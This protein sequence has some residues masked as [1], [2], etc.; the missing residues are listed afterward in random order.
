[1]SMNKKIGKGIL[2]SL[3]L[4][5][6]VFAAGTQL[7][8]RPNII[9][10]LADDMGVGDF[11][12]GG[13][14]PSRTPVLDKL[15]SK[16]TVLKQHYA[17]SAVCSPSRACLL[18]GRYPQRTGVLDTQKV[19]NLRNL[20]LDERTIADVL[21]DAGYVT[22]LI[23]K[24]HLGKSE[25][26]YYPW[27]RGFSHVAVLDKT[28]HWD[29][30]LN[31]N[32]VQEESDGRY[33]ADV[34]NDDAVQFIRTHKDEPFFLYLAHFAPHEPLLAVEED[35]AQ[36]RV[37]GFNEKVSTLYAMIYRMDQGIGRVLRELKAQGLDENTLVIFASDNGAHFATSWLDRTS[38]TRFNCGL[39][40]HKDLVYEG[41]IRVPAF[42]FWPAGKLKS[43]SIDSPTH[44]ADWF[45]TLLAVAGVPVPED[46]PPLDG[47]NL[48]PLLRGEIQ[49]QSTSFCWQYSR[50][51]PTDRYNIAIREG[52]WKLIRPVEGDG[53][54]GPVLGILPPKGIAKTDA[55]LDSAKRYI[56]EILDRPVAQLFNLKDD[57]FEQNDLA[58]QNPEKVMEMEKQLNCWFSSIMT[59]CTTRLSHFDF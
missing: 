3:L 28:H 30:I 7:S 2:L 47:R 40:G 54:D 45:P 41:G 5:G 52:D 44:F 31:R 55:Q 46:N 51:Y 43:G 19:Y 15:A 27:N 34:L 38:V 20:S 8:E 17:G 33:L 21:S 37:A 48:L 39:R 10:I 4:A 59:D 29:W 49:G 13:G 26:E 23:G 12:S 24:W 11:G 9:F 50:Y 25:P 53:V 35:V 36:F 22:G 16:G 42:L 18:T 1:M 56:P 32:G 58:A 14:G 57:P 6:S